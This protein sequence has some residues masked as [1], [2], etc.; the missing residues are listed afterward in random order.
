M[1][2]LQEKLKWKLQHCLITLFVFLKRI[3]II[4][5]LLAANQIS[6]C[7]LVLRCAYMVLQA[8][9]KRDIGNTYNS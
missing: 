5:K 6:V 1:N 4:R 3:T 8:T 7:I 9:S 2:G